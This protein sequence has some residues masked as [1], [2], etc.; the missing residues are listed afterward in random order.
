VQYRHDKGEAS[1][2][3][4]W[5]ND[6]ENDVVQHFDGLLDDW[7]VY[8]QAL[9]QSEIQALMNSAASSTPISVAT[10]TSSS[11]LPALRGYWPLDESSGQWQDGG[12][13][14]NHLVDV[15]TVGS[16]TGRVNLAA[17]FESSD[18]EYLKIADT[19]QSGLN[20][21]GDLTLVGWINPESLGQ[22]MMMASKYDFGSGNNRAYRFGI[23]ETKVLHFAVSPDGQY[24]SEYILDGKTVL[25]SGQWYHTAA[26]FDA[27][28]RTMRLYLNGELEATQTVSFNSI[29]MSTAPFMLGSNMQRGTWTTVG[30]LKVSSPAD[31][32][33]ISVW[34]PYNLLPSSQQ[35]CWIGEAKNKTDAF[36]TNPPADYIPNWTDLRLT[37]YAISSTEASTTTPTSSGS[38]LAGVK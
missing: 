38:D 29:K 20:I 26:V 27:N 30:R 11:A 34:V 37:T 13:L 18:R 31:G 6:E 32:N 22:T 2:I 33:M 3:N 12:T 21:T 16:A 1:L 8:G 36:S 10:S 15:N 17:D 23:F 19:A 28:G 24:S 35:F 7:R 25:H 14:A 9:S 4:I 5:N